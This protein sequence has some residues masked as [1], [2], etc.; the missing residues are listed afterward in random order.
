MAVVAN[1]VDAPFL[2]GPYLRKPII[3]YQEWF[4][5]AEIAAQENCC[6]KTIRN[7][8]KLGYLKANRRGPRNI[9]IHIDDY[10]NMYRP[11]GKS[12]LRKY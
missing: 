2:G 11:W 7:Y 5:V 8:I 6:E 10:G 12:Y 4:T 9:F 1:Q 3:M